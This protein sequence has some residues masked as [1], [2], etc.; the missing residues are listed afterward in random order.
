MT[1]QEFLKQVAAR[2]GVASTDVS[3]HMYYNATPNLSF[4]EL[5]ENKF[6]QKQLYSAVGFGVYAGGSRISSFSLTPLPGC[7]GVVV[8]H[9]ASVHSDYQRKGIG[10][11]CHEFRVSMCKHLNYTLMLCTDV[12]TNQP[13]QKILDK[14]GW[15]HIF[16][17]NNKRTGNTVAISV[18]DLTRNCALA[19]I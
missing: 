19:R 17:F 14:H 11:L 12:V 9:N 15:Q 1:K 8:S 6:E 16:Q 10:N 18:L 4:E 2:L 3:L 13:Q 7:C 5:F